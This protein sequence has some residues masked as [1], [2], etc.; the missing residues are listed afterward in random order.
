VCGICLRTNDN[1]MFVW[2][3]VGEKMAG[4]V[5]KKLVAR[6][7]KRYQ[8]QVRAGEDQVDLRFWKKPVGVN[9]PG[10]PLKFLY[11]SDAAEHR[12]LGKLAGEV[13]SYQ[14]QHYQTK[15]MIT[16]AVMITMGGLLPGVYLHDNIAWID[17]LGISEFGVLGVESY[18]AP[19]EMMS[20]P[21]VILDTNVDI[22]GRVVLVVEDLGD[23]G[24]TPEL[25]AK[26]LKKRGAAKVIVLLAYLK[27]KAKEVLKGQELMYF[28]E[29]T[30]DT[31]IIT[32]RERVETLRK[33]VPHW[34][35]ELGRNMRQCRSYLLA[36]GYPKYLI[37][38]HL[39]EFF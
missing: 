36:I 33:R 6:V 21:R 35:D 11:V 27:P 13:L 10:D 32:P 29:T 30:Q 23:T 24:R 34:R 20:K 39:P 9:V 7:S 22:K 4:T 14:K 38:A 2:I 28:G 12:M 25:V 16:R 31:W 3:Y 17:S 1:M 15:E 5:T 26:M 37:E 19:G 18:V 8:Q